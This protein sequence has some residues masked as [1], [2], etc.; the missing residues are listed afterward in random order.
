MDILGISEMRWTNS[1]K[2]T[3]EE[4]TVLYSGHQS[5]HA[6]G[7]GIVMSK[8]AAASMI[9][10]RP[11]SERIIAARFQGA[12]TKITFIQIYA[13]TE[14]ASDDNKDAFYEDLAA[15]LQQTPHHDMVILAGDFNAQIGPDRSGF[16]HTIGLHGSAIMTNDNGYRLLSL[17]AAHGLAVSNTY[18]PHKRIHKMTWKAPGAR[19]VRNEIDYIC[20]SNNFRSSILDV[21]SYRGA[22]VGTDH[23]LLA[24]KC[25][26]RLKRQP[27]KDQRPKPF[28]VVKLKDPELKRQFNAAVRNRFELLTPSADV[29]AQWTNYRDAL[30]AA[31]EETIGRRRGTFRERW[32]QER[33]WKLIDERRLAK[34]VRDQAQGEAEQAKA[35]EHY[36]NLDRQV[37]RSCRRDKREWIERKTEEAQLAADRNDSKT[38]YQIVREVSGSSTGRG[39]PIKDRNGRT[40]LTQEEREKRWVEHFSQVLNQPAPTATFDPGILVP[41]PDLPVK[42]GQITTDETKNAM[43]ALKRGKAAG[44]DGIPPELIKIGDAAHVGSLTNLLNSCWMARVVPKEWRSGVIVTLPKKGDLSKCDNWRGITLLSVPGKILSTV[45]L[46]RLQ[47]A[48]DE[49]LREEQAGF[50]RGRSCT[51]QIFI[52][53]Q[54]IEQTLEYQQ[55]LSLNFIDFVKAF[56]S[57]HRDTL[58]K[59]ARTYG[60]PA[61]FIEIFQNLYNGSRCCVRTEDGMTDYFTIESGVRQ[62]C[63]LSP[64]LFLLAIDFVNRNAIDSTRL[65]LEWTAN[66]LLADL[67]FADDVA[68]FGP[69]YPALRDLTGALER[70][71]ACVGLRISDQKTKIIRVGYKTTLPRIT[72]NG[73]QVEELQ[74][75][76]YL[77]SVIAADG[78]A[79]RDVTCRIGKAFAVFQR[80]CSIWNS[81]SLSLHL[82]LRL[83]STIVLPT[84]LYAAETWKQTVA[85]DQKLDVFQQRC[86]RRIL[87]ISYRDRVT[88]DEIY[89]RT[90]TKPLSTVVTERRLQFTGHI[91]RLPDH[92]LAKVAMR[93][94]PSRGRRGQGRP[95]TTWRRTLME[96]LRATDIE[97]DDQHAVDTAAAD[98]TRWKNLVAQCAERRRR[99]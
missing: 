47:R 19:G 5:E 1:G 48:I 99:N 49:Q 77:G 32:I 94:R 15:E 18:F 66:R 36:S 88:N 6:R 51:E 11:A 17:C 27:L 26:L 93:W 2:M 64:M 20:V 55:R 40:L 74:E 50:Q 86:L 34:H 84:A 57:I 12:H 75:F 70:S 33:S 28:D 72:I 98:R 25:R 52:L 96:D 21:R 44:I 91:L 78:D 16:E 45:L 13:P 29:E 7:V 61:A 62:G 58:W 97:W 56:D 79:T 30:T 14:D 31:A 35:E 67:D 83:F 8:K 42:L 85:I 4:K 81:A 46:Q 24:A 38:L 60:I 69:T 87:K 65:G 9:S 54:V 39:V 68:L 76:T 73:N 90:N 59:I 43:K 71:A 22:D 53:R 37:K 80:L 92:R 41:A 3:S 82:K 89:R 10:W 23:F 95:K 63:I